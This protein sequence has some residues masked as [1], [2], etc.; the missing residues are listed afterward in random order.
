MRIAS[1]TFRIGFGLL[2]VVLL[3]VVGYQVLRRS[4]FYAPD[5]LLQQADGSSWPDIQVQT[6]PSY[7]HEG[8]GSNLL[9]AALRKTPTSRPL[10][11]AIGG[12]V[13]FASHDPI[14]DLRLPPDLVWHHVT[15]SR[16]PIR[17]QYRTQLKTADTRSHEELVY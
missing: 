10:H 3:S 4:S 1:P 2:L 17:S 13:P 15:L 14:A 5:A 12:S 9:P 16:R 6:S 8:L 11:I 7:I